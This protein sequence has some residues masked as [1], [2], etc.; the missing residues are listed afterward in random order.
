MT[1]GGRLKY[2]ITLTALALAMPAFGDD[3]PALGNFRGLALSSAT[4]RHPLTVRGGTPV[5]C[6]VPE[7]ST[8]DLKKCKVQDASLVVTG[9]EENALNV[10]FEKVNVLRSEGKYAGWHYYYKGTANLTI[11]GKPVVAPVFATL[12]LDDTNPNRLF[13]V[14]ELTDQYAK[15]TIEAYRE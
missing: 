11:G 2:L 7:G 14:I 9:P 3:A 12:N 8:L 1:L 13:G 4:A 5:A 15:T 6:E 10:T